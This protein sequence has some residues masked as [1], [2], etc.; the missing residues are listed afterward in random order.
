MAIQIARTLGPLG[1]GV[2]GEIGC[3]MEACVAQRYIDNAGELNGFLKPVD[4]LFE[5]PLPFDDGCIVMPKGYAPRIDRT[6]LKR[7]CVRSERFPA[8]S[9][10]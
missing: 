10:H 1:N 4:R 6:A 3:W 2:A 9:I 8:R 7:F 5:N